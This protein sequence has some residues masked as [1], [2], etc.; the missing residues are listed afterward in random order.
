MQ[1]AL[2]SKFAY[3]TALERKFGIEDSPKQRLYR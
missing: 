2:G 3:Y 1:I